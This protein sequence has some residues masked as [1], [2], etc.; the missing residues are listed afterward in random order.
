MLKNESAQARKTLL[1]LLKNRSS[2]DAMDWLS[3]VS[4]ENTGEI[5]WSQLAQLFDQKYLIAGFKERHEMT[6]GTRYGDMPIGH[7]RVQHAAKVFFDGD[8]GFFRSARISKTV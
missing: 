8:V 2:Q 7:W 3:K 6:L 5:D 4:T 1:G